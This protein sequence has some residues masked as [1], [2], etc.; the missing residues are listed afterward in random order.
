MD[1]KALRIHRDCPC[2]ARDLL[3]RVVAF[4]PGTIRDFHALR[5][6]DQECPACASPLSGTG[7]VNYIFKA[8]SSTLIPSWSGLL[9]LTK[10]ECTAG[11]FGNSLSN[12]RH[13]QLKRPK[14][15]RSQRTNSAIC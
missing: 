8:R 11:H 6:H 10:Y 13:W 14:L 12:I 1:T 3:A 9:H 5:V 4:A 2:D 7:L 15:A